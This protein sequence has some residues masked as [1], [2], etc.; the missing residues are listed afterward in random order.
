MNRISEKA[1]EIISRMR[2]YF[3]DKTGK[4]LYINEEPLRLELFTSEQMER[5][6]KTLAQSHKLSDKRNKGQ[7]LRRL[8]DNEKTLLEIHQLLTE[9]IEANS[10]I[11]PAGEWLTDNFYLIEDQIRTAKRHLPRG[12]SENLPQLTSGST[13]VYDIALQIISHSDGR[14]DMDSLSN[15]INA[16]ETVTHLQIGELWAIPI[17]LR[18]AL[19]ENLRR[20]A[21]GIAIDRIDRNLANHWAQQMI[22]VSEKAPQDL[23]ITI[24]EMAR[25][26][27]PLVS[28]FVA[29]ITRQ[30]SGKGPGLALALNWIE[31]RLLE[32]GTTSTEMIFAENQ[33]Q[34]ADQ[35]SMRNSIGSLRALST[36][37]WR[38]FVENH[39]IVEQILRK[40]PA[41]V[42]AQM[43]FATRDR[44]RHVIEDVSKKSKKPEQEVAQIAINLS[45]QALNGENKRSFHVGYYLVDN[46]LRE[47]YTQTKTPKPFW[48]FRKNVIRRGTFFLYLSSISVVTLAIA[49]VVYLKMRT[50]YTYHVGLFCIIIF[51]T[52]I[53]AS[54]LALTLVNF[55]CTL[56][57]KPRLLPRMDF[58]EGIPAESRTLVVIPSLLTSL[59]DIDEL[60]DDLEVRFLANRDKNL[61]FGLLT[62]FTD[63][64][65]EKLPQD[66][67]LLSFACKR[68]EKLNEKY[69]RTT[70]S[71]FFLFHRPRI[72]NPSEK[73]WMGHERKRGKLSDLNALLRGKG[74]DKFSKIT[75]NAESLQQIKYVITLDAD[76]QLPHGTAWKL[77]ATMA[78]PLNSAYYNEKK[79]RVTEGYGIL[80]PRVSVSL[81]DITASHYAKLHGDEPGIDPYTRATS[82]VYQDMFAEG[83][84]IGKGI[85]EVDIFEKVLQG[86]FPENRIL[87]HDLLEG[88]Y[89]RSGLLSDVQLYEKY[90]GTYKADVKRRI[91]WIRGDWQIIPWCLPFVPDSKHHLRKNTL[92]ALS[93]WKIFDNLRRSLVPIALTAFILLSWTVLGNPLFW[94][95]AVSV[96]IV[97]PIFVTSFWNA[98]KKPKDLFLTQHLLLYSLNTGDVFI[99]TIFSLICLPHEAYYNLRAIIRTCWRMLIT[100]RKLLQWNTAAAEEKISKENGLLR[101]YAFM[102]AEPFLA[103]AALAYSIWYHPICLSVAAPILLLWLLTP[104]VTWWTSLPIAKQA[105]ALTREQ[106]TF[107]HM[108]SRKTWGFFEKYVSEDD[109]WLPPDNF[110]ETPTPRIAHRTSPTNIGLYLLSNLSAYDFGYQSAGQFLKRTRQT[111][112]TISK[113]QKYNGHLYNWYSTQSLE[114]L[115]PHYVSTVDSGNLVGHLLTLKQ[116]ILNIAEQRITGRRLFDGLYDT[117]HVLAQSLNTEH[118][119]ELKDFEN[120]LKNACDEPPKSIDKVAQ[121]LQNLS[122]VYSAASGAIHTEPDSPASWWKELLAKQITGFQEDI[123]IFAPLQF[124]SSA[125]KGFQRTYGNSN[126]TLTEI[127]KIADELPGEVKKQKDANDP[128]GLQWLNSLQNSFEESAPAINAFLREIE[129]LSAQCDELAN[130]EW[131]FLYDKEKNLLTIGYRPDEHASDAGYY[132]LLAS[133]ARL[134]IFAAIAQGKVPEDSWFALSR[135]LTTT[136]SVSAL[137]SWSGSMFEY[138]MPLLVMPTYENTLLDQTYKTSVKRQIEYGN[139]RGI[140]WG[141][142]ESEYNTVD[143]SSNYQYRAFGTPGLGLKRGLGEDMVVAPYATAL[144][145][146]V[147]PEKACKNMELMSQKGFEGTYGFYEAV[148]YTPARLQRGQ[149]NAII[150]AYMS[151]HQGMVLLS[152]AYLLLNKP[153]QKYFEAE[154]QFQAN[155]LLLQERI[156]KVSSTYAHTAPG[157]DKTY[158]SP[159]GTVVRV[160]N[161]PHTSIPEIQLLSNGRYHVMVT[162][163]GAGYSRWKD[164]AVTRWREDGTCDNWGSFCYIRDLEENEFWSNTYQPSLKKVQNYEAAFSQSRADFRGLKNDIEMHTEIVV[165]PED[166]IEM[167]RLNLTNRSKTDK[168]IEITSYAEVVLTS[169]SSDLMQPAFSNLFVETEIVK[170]R[171]AILC[172]RRPKSSGEQPPW[173]FH[174]MSVDDAVIN[175]ISYETDRLKFIGRGNNLSNPAAM[176]KPGALSGSQGSVLDPIVSIRYKITI[177]AESSACIDIITGASDKRESCQSLVEKYQDTHHKSRVFELAWTHSQVVLHH[178][179]ASESDAQLYGKL[180]GSVIFIN[181]ALRADPSVLIK[182]QRG[183]S[184]LWGYSISGD[185]PIVLIKIKSQENLQLVK[186]MI[187]AH[188]YWHLKGLWVDLV[189]WNEDHGGYRKQ[190]QSQIQDLIAAEITDKPGGIFVRAADQISNEDRILFQTVARVIL[191]DSDGTLADHLNRKSVPRPPIPYINIMSQESFDVPQAVPENLRFFNGLGGFSDDGSE[192]IIYLNGETRT[193]AP[194]AN[195]IANPLFGTVISESGQAYT[196]GENAHEYRLS[197]WNNDPICDTAGEAYY[198][199]DE[200]TGH[201]WSFTPL[202]RGGKSVYKVRHGMGYSVFEHTENGIQSE[203]WVYVDLEYTIKFT[204]LKMR[205]VSGRSRRLSVTGYVEWVLGEQ[206]TKTAMHVFTEFDPVSG[207]IFARNPYNSEFNGH[208]A[209]FDVDE[210]RKTFT[211]DRAEFIGRNGSLR[212]PDGMNRVRLSGK[213]GAALDPCTAV[214]ITF[215]LREGEE[216]EIIYRMGTCGNVN[217]VSNIVRKFRGMEEATQALEKVR[218]FWK[219]TLNALQIETP[220]AA[221]NILANGWLTYQVMASRLWGRSGYYQSGGA[222]GFRDQLQDVLSL[223]H[224]KPE[225]GRKQILLAASR[226]F[227]D[228]DVQHWWHPPLGRGVRTRCSDDY[229]WLPFVTSQYILITNDHA[230]LDEMVP[231]LEGR[232]LNAEEDS[233]YDLPAQSQTTE[234][235]Y[236]HCVKAIKYGFRYG[237]HGLPLMGTG[238]WND[239]MDRVGKE[240]K[241]ESVW[242]A[243]FLYDILNRF[244]PIAEMRNDAPFAE[245]CRKEAE[246]LKANIA[247]NGWDGEWFRRAY[248]DDGSPLGSSQNEEC[249][250]DSLPQSWSVIS[251]AAETELAQ[252][253]M[254]SAYKYLVH[255]DDKFISLLDP[256]F[257]KSALDPGYIK[258]Y[259]PGVRENGGQYTHAAIWMTI[260]FAQLGNRERTWELLNIL[261]P[262]NHSSDASKIA[263]YKVEPY[264]IAADVYS[265]SPFTG[266]GG[267]TWYSGSASWM[268]RLITEFFLGIKQRGVKLTFEPCVPA[269][270]QTFKVHYRFQ[271]TIYHIVFEQKN[272]EG[273]MQIT[274][275]GKEQPDNAITL[276]DDSIDHTVNVTLYR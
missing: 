54:Q 20:V 36:M 104:A 93:R 243:F 68:I 254:E 122:S 195:V 21:T 250:I 130:V 8:A 77:T 52:L 196:W 146:M 231:F 234:K 30:L 140:P 82:D 9:T 92:S 230:I 181:P 103:L 163:S 24:A 58:S 189:I 18:L 98:F 173:M 137:L 187:Q 253:A 41:H 219:H 170:E 132:D 264:V 224:I 102:W 223:F 144:A 118:P 200:E 201:Y 99:K 60:V 204:V 65:S 209:F 211:C 112:D 127:I 179:N 150:H 6:S 22:A 121:Y 35:V 27:P 244:I 245:E 87:S 94:T 43:E 259:V 119:E 199:R 205:N 109:H 261:N 260:A 138:L 5:Y 42:Y 11:T 210:R 106:Y 167:R 135:L 124:L 1:E 19:I 136:G 242:L 80:Q 39:S 265:L 2:K 257:D 197:P 183:Q 48:G 237:E 191:S 64:P 249:R 216:R 66:D 32:S 129:S 134:G 63:A 53:S 55:L 154:L 272:E 248:F 28:A 252:K 165:S 17:M 125:P 262:L 33:K 258:G 268:Y 156:P 61:Q 86:R 233:Y 267:W 107:L 47:L 128:E 4:H 44:Y 151:H 147:E 100:H 174:M 192:Y 62:D 149:T 56:W 142:S 171:N 180:A 177:K 40:D 114:P 12:Y 59:S 214:Q 3:Q 247:K 71:L 152:L 131:N 78:H 226:Q 168:T 31:Q 113:L 169:P 172:T 162:N 160:L 108:L 155:L 190:L 161:T 202:P 198:L 145:L 229:L 46:G 228:G 232:H 81:P 215:D 50:E 105:S 203:L 75:G 238:D 133:E 29:E 217:D 69:E 266:H 186:Q 88:C 273:K 176:Q 159:G 117:F 275:D 182:N 255:K 116:G 10:L 141:N 51:L 206:R 157:V 83:S 246:N 143:A 57:I 110:Q 34:A 7:L 26:H 79:Q 14:I 25:S 178:I 188:S 101:S 269:E 236:E 184:G 37:D 175:E 256:P 111:F 239:G 212:N 166:D 240:G 225:L 38:D 241:G 74:T 139:Q 126:L 95:L 115:L 158:T 73:A 251:K 270:W 213:I 76:T 45:E 164:F 67:E 97:L 23:I 235:L 96:I 218:Q 208:I 263:T 276:L 123:K 84:F 120:L 221:T 89:I 70:N 49:L 90:P 13:R 207:A 91:R 220:D 15:F 274:L 16:Y 148:D 72:W 193:P 185:L 85:Y 194:W 153:M 271:E 227:K 222:F